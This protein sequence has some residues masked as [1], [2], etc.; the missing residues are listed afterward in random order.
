MAVTI[1]FYN[2]TRKLFANGEVDLSNLTV[3]LRTAATT[4]NPAHTGVGQLSGAEVYGNGWPAG[5][6]QIANASITI[7]NTN[8]ARLDGDNISVTAT[9]GSIGPA[10]SAVVVDGTT[11]L[12][13][14][15][16]DGPQQAGETTPFN[17]NWHQ[18]GIV[19]WTS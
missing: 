9:G 10:S 18:N 7:V 11:P 12:L 3:M 8:E 4:F 1:S 14:I 16:F 13:F 2:H 15:D 6:A 19:R 17:I 5:G